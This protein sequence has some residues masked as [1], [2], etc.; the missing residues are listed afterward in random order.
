[1]GS[2]GRVSILQRRSGDR[3]REGTVVGALLLGAIGYW[4]G[5][6]VC[7]H[8]PEPLGTNGRDCGSDALMV[9]LVG[10]GVG[11]GLGYLIGRGIDK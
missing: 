10:G 1:M 6:E 4:I 7:A 3:R 2:A 11:A 8:Q 9:G 5:H